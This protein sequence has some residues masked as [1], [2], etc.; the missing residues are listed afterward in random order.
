MNFNN[1]QNERITLSDERIIW[2]SRSA[3]VVVTVWCI[4][5]NTP[6]LLLGKRG[7]GCPDEVGK[8]NLP[9]GYLDWNETLAEA[10]EREVYEE[11]GLNIRAIQEDIESV[12]ISH[13]DQPWKVVSDIVSINSKQTISHHHALIYEAKKL[14]TLSTAHCEPDEVEA[15]RWVTSAELDDYDY[16]FDHLAAI[17][18]FMEEESRL[19]L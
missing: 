17:R 12:M 11:T 19:L 14:A 1:K 4:V 13:L 2:L 3:A 18:E 16:A 8:W 7:C 6:Y 10:A 5:G 9:C 15:L